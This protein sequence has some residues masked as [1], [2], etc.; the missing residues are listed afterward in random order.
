MVISAIVLS[1]QDMSDYLLGPKVARLVRSANFFGLVALEYAV[2]KCFK[3]GYQ[4]V[5][6]FFCSKTHGRVFTGFLFGELRCILQVSMQ[7]LVVPFP[8]CVFEVSIFLKPGCGACFATEH[9]GGWG[10]YLR[11]TCSN[12][13]ARPAFGKCFFNLL[14]GR[15]RLEHERS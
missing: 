8:V 2:T 12:R 7:Y 15:W 9:A 1:R 11:F 13:V 6:L 4:I 5:P 14:L 3:I 10:A